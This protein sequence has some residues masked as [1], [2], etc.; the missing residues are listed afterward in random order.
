MSSC[1]Q[2]ML[3]DGS[4]DEAGRSFLGVRIPQ[5]RSTISLWESTL[6]TQHHDG[7]R[8]GGFERDRSVI[9]KGFLFARSRK[10]SI[11]HTLE[12]DQ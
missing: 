3:V 5:F 1:C 12:K 4:S 11:R 6:Q 8:Y 7:L 2:Q 9:D 10:S